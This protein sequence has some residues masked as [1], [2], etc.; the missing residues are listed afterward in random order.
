MLENLKKNLQDFKENFRVIVKELETQK[1]CLRMISMMKMSGSKIDQD[2]HTKR[3][4]NIKRDN[5]KKFE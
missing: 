5:P 1:N 3:H 4:K 2:D